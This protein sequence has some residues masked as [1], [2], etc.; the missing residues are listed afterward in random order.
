MAGFQ[1]ITE[2]ISASLIQFAIAPEANS[3]ILLA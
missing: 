1:V 2:G 3:P